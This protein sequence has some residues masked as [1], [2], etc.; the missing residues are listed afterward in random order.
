MGNHKA[1]KFINNRCVGL[2]DRPNEEVRQG[3]EGGGGLWWT[4]SL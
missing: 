4:I 2:R 1:N 3:A